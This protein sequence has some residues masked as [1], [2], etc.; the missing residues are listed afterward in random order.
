M[1]TSGLGT[2]QSRS[3]LQCFV[4]VPP[5]VRQHEFISLGIEIRYGIKFLVY[6]E[7][8]MNRTANVRRANREYFASQHTC[9]LFVS[10]FFTLSERP[11][12]PAIDLVFALTATTGDADDIFKRMKDAVKIITDT[13]GMNK[14][15]YSAIVYGAVT[16]RIFDFKT[17]FSTREGLKYFIERLRKVSGGPDTKAALEQAM[18]VI[19]DSIPRPTAKTVLVLITDG[20]LPDNPQEVERFIGEIKEKGIHVLTFALVNNP[21]TD[22][23]VPNKVEPRELAEKVMQNVLAGRSIH[24][25]LCF[26]CN[27]HHYDMVPGTNIGLL[28]FFVSTLECSV[29]A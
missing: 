7:N 5:A 15:R 6:E 23:E 14:L 11:K 9:S 21:K 26:I 10:F 29:S 8:T 25:P 2:F 16:K 12:V 22:F 18:R 3:H 13:Y 17:D 28:C 4:V 20:A 19:K 27:S 24:Q 1:H